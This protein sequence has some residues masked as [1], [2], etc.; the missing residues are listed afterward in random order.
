M[1]F[2]Y[3]D[4]PEQDRLLEEQQKIRDVVAAPISQYELDYMKNHPALRG[5]PYP[6]YLMEHLSN[7]SAFKN[8]DF[9]TGKIIIMIEN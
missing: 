6:P 9:K 1:K 2:M 3:Y 8:S 7:H 5:E 4:S